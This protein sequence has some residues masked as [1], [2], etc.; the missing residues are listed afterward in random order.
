MVSVVRNDNGIRGD[1]HITFDMWP[2]LSVMVLVLDGHQRV[3]VLYMLSCQVAS[4]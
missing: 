1:E 2:A 4:Q 3:E